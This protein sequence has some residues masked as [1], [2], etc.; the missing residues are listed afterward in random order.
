MR[1]SLTRL[2]QVIVHEKPHFSIGEKLKEGG[3]KGVATYFWFFTMG[4]NL[5]IK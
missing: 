3:E 1:G 5:V 4:K 2:I